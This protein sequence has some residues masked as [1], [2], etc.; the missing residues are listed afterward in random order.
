MNALRN[1]ENKIAVEIQYLDF[2]TSLISNNFQK[3]T[4]EVIYF[5]QTRSKVHTSER[6]KPKLKTDQLY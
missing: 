4:N 2:L 5:K 3:F 6:A 1:R